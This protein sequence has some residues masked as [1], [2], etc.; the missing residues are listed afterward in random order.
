MKVLYFFIVILF[1]LSTVCA[2]I[3]VTELK[4]VGAKKTG[5]LDSNGW[6]KTGLLLLN[7]NQSARSDW[8]A[9]GEDFMIG[10]NFVLN[11]A[12]HHRK[13]KY[14]FDGYFDLE[15][16]IVEASSFKEFRK[17]NDRCDLTVEFE[18]TLDSKHWYYG[19]LGNINTQFFNG[20]DYSVPTKDRI[21]AFLSPGKFLLSPGFDFKDYNKDHYFSVFASPVTFRWVTKRAEEFYYDSKFG[22]DSANKTVT[23][24]G[25]YLTVHYNKRISKLTNYIG[26]L[27]LFSNYKDKPQN[28]DFLMNNLLTYNIEK[29]FAL[30]IILDI[31]YDHDIVQRIQ[32]QEIFGIG[33]RVNL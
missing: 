15:L 23:A 18:H 3:S 16:G 8:S 29:R 6:K 7:I 4:R 24:I 19:V 13:G 10:L 11:Q 22:V 33:F 12:V 32:I 17:T 26:R 2:Q 27:D 30:S 14:T 25:A 5:S 28:V 1:S 31:I 9:G 21:S 20:Y